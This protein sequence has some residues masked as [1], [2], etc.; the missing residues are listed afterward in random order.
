MRSLIDKY[1]DNWEEGRA[2]I[3]EIIDRLYAACSVDRRAVVELIIRADSD[4]SE[5]DRVQVANTEAMARGFGG[6]QL[7]I[8]SE[9][10]RL[11]EQRK[12]DW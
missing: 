5:A 10:A 11:Q 4:E 1:R 6:Q 8:S 12:Q 2:K 3:T 7:Q 9:V